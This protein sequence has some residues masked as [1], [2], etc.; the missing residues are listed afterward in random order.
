MLL[1]DTKMDTRQSLADKVRNSFTEVKDSLREYVAM[2]A[3]KYI[4]LPASLAVGGVALEEGG[5]NTS[6]A[7]AQTAPI[8]QPTQDPNAKKIELSHFRVYPIPSNADGI[9]TLLLEWDAG[10]GIQKYEADVKTKDG[11]I[12]YNPLITQEVTTEDG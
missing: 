9:D 1:G 8:A 12:H 4:I 3:V 6:N 2:P 5:I 10:L 7:Y 11:T